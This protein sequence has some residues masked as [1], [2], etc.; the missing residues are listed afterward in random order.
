M[1]Q[2]SEP[3]TALAL[4]M[5]RRQGLE[6]Q[7]EMPGAASCC[8]PQI[9]E[10]DGFECGSPSAEVLTAPGGLRVTKRTQR[11]RASGWVK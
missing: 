6:P 11:D 10:S 9:R 2:N 3:Q 1:E 4:G 5:E 8:I 7:R